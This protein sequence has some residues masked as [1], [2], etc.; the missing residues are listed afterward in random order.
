MIQRL[1]KNHSF[2]LENSGQEGK[3]KHPYRAKA[4]S[5]SNMFGR[6]ALLWVP[7][8]RHNE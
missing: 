6:I 3:L 2:W 1:L 7:E 4:A 8:A 5:R